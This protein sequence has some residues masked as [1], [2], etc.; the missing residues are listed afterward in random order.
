MSDGIIREGADPKPFTFASFTDEAEAAEAGR[1]KSAAAEFKP[2]HKA[3]PT[4]VDEDFVLGGF[5]FE[6]KGGYRRDEILKKTSDEIEEMVRQAHA[7]VASIERDAYQKGFQEGMNT[8]RTEG[9][10]EATVLM[11]TLRDGLKQLDAARGVYYAK[12]EKEMVDLSLL[13]AA[14]IVRREVA[15]D[16]GIVVEVL[17]KAVAE[18]ETRQNIVV[19]LSPKDM[20]LIGGMRESLQ[21]EMETIERIEFRADQAITPGGCIL[22]TNIGSLDATVENRLMNIHRT[23]RE[24]IGK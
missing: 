8:G 4:A 24:Q 14:E 3:A 12:A 13:I 22:E 17:R 10:A 11:D 20:D 2:D 23:L 21:Q 7:R 5:D 18:L 6:F 1:R 19:R 15:Q 16:P 9:F